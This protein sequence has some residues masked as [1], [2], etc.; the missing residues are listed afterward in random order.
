MNDSAVELWY[1]E[2]DAMEISDRDFDVADSAAL[3]DELEP[4]AIAAERDSNFDREFS[5]WLEWLGR[6]DCLVLFVLEQC[7][8]EGRLLPWDMRGARLMTAPPEAVT[9]LHW[10]WEHCPKHVY[11]LLSHYV[12]WLVRSERARRRGTPNWSPRSVAPPT[13][14]M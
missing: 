13:G 3:P 5:E 6:T 11:V 8:S 7:S 2:A 10:F 12:F 14:G 9:Q 4:Y 1:A